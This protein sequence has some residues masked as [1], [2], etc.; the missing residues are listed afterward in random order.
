MNTA[1]IDTIT[2]DN[3]A[4]INQYPGIILTCLLL[5]PFPGA[6]AAPV[7]AW[8][9]EVWCLGVKGRMEIRMEDG[10]RVDCLTDTHAIEFEFARKWPEA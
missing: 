1:M 9:Q 7:E 2:P 3:H 8:Y 6:Q 10:R 4:A 5:C